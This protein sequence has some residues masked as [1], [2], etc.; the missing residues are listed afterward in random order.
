MILLSPAKINIGLQIIRRRPDGFH[1]LRS[2]MFQVGLKDI[3]EIREAGRAALPL[4]FSQS[5]IPV[6][7]DSGI[8]LCE[9]AHE[10]FTSQKEIPQV[11]IHLHKQIPVGAGLGGGSSN[12]TMTLQGL[13]RITP[14]P[15]TGD[16]LNEMAAKLGSDCPYFLHDQTMMM[17][18][19]GEILTPSP[20]NLD[21]LWLVLLFP[22]IHISTAEAYSG[23]MPVMPGAHLEQLVAAPVD[24]WR[25]QVV[26]DFEA[27]IF[28]KHPELASLKEKLY[29][30]GA[31]YA[32][33]SGSGSS[34]YGIFS[35]KPDLPGTIS[36]HVIWEGKA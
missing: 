4:K 24:E 34:L 36:R 10:I 7:D 9:K 29:N 11:E 22:G 14:A 27:G 15:L 13:N 12:A 28:E 35:G 31:R 20:V 5:G 25:E 26:N 21:G 30:A 8:N 18:G 19:R 1:D 23:V 2:V 32:S 33:L 16:R 17:E 3:L 6:P